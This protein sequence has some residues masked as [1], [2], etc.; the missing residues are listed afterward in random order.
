MNR[1]R[2]QLTLASFV[3]YGLWRATRSTRNVEVALRSGER[4][5][6]RPLPS[7]DLTTAYEVF[8]ARL[9]SPVVTREAPRFVVDVGSN[10][11]YTCVLWGHKFPEAEILAFEPHPV[12]LRQMRTNLRLNRLEGRVRVVAAA[13]S[14]APGRARFSDAENES[15]LLVGAAGERTLEVDVVDFFREVGDRFI[16]LLKMDIEGGEYALLEDPRFAQ[17][18]IGRIAL[19]W[20]RKPDHP[21]GK[22]WC[23]RRLSELGYQVYEEFQPLETVGIL[24]AQR[25]RA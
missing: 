5:E 6:I 22:E 1:L 16:D 8:V 19:E 15:S 11:G 14:T 25:A 12:H 21:D 9:Y 20:H 4:F 17:L 23:K 18:K 24:Y 3:K 2:D 7:T 13:A 10:V